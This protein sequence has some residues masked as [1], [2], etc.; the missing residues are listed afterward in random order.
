[1]ARKCGCTARPVPVAALRGMTAVQ[2]LGHI[3]DLFIF[4]DWGNGTG[5]QIFAFG[6]NVQTEMEGTMLKKIRCF[7]WNMR[8]R[9]K[10]RQVIMVM[11]IAVF[12]MVMIV[13]LSAKHLVTSRHRTAEVHMETGVFAGAVTGSSVSTG[14]ALSAEQEAVGQVQ[15]EEPVQTPVEMVTDTTGLDAFHG[16][17]TE[18]AYT[19][20]EE[21]IKEECR[22]RGCKS[23]KKLNYQQTAEGS[24]EVASFVLLSD[25]GILRCDYNLKSGAVSVSPTE[26]SETDI[27]AM[28][29]AEIKAEQ[30]VLERQQAADKKKAELAKKKSQKKAGTKAKKHKGKLKRSLPAGNQQNQRK[31][32]LK[33]ERKFETNKQRT[34]EK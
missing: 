1:M 10:G 13:G 21:Q 12:G 5:R 16:F 29:D 34:P 18:N 23:A 26:Y 4:G 19:I 33:E 24:F 9:G 27:M 15:V 7:Y 3:P 17:M 11:I 31:Q 22:K 8:D 20:M 25:G 32:N 28:H 30:E 2:W 6:H 14:S